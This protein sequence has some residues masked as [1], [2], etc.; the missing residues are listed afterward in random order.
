MKVRMLKCDPPSLAASSAIIARIDEA[1]ARPKTAPHAISFR[2]R[3][4]STA[5]PIV[6]AGVT[7]SPSTHG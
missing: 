2:G 1:Q 7:S 6:A 4:S 5:V 3:R